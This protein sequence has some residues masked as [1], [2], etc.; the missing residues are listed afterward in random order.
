MQKCFHEN[1]FGIVGGF[2]EARR[3]RLDY[4]RNTFNEFDVEVEE[5][6]V[7]DLVDKILLLDKS[8]HEGLLEALREPVEG[9][10]HIIDRRTQRAIVD[11]RLQDLGFKNDNENK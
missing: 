8:Y 9:Y 4:I 11:G 1:L 7:N 3:W 10:E 5:R 2:Q 6:I